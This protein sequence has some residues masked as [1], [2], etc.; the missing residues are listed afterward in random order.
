MIDE[1][2]HVIDCIKFAPDSACQIIQ[3]ADYNLVKNGLNPNQ[4]MDSGGNIINNSTS[5]MTF[6]DDNQSALEESKRLDDT[7]ASYMN[8]D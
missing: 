7:D 2:E 8:A 4:T 1:H 6:G 3:K 5:D